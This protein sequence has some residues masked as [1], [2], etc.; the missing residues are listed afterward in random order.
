MYEK[1]GYEPLRID[2]LHNQSF[3]CDFSAKSFFIMLAMSLVVNLL[4]FFSTFPIA[5]DLSCI[6]LDMEF[7]ITLIFPL[8]SKVSITCY[9][10]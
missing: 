3:F 9:S 10:H 2:Y 4:I 6:E 5:N 8:I 7:I 1:K